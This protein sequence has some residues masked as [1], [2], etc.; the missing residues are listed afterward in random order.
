MTIKPKTKEQTIGGSMIRN[1][2][3]FTSWRLSHKVYVRLCSIH[4][5]KP[6]ILG[7]EEFC[8]AYNTLR[9][10]QYIYAMAYSISWAMQ[11][12]LAMQNKVGLTVYVRPCSMFSLGYTS[13]YRAMQY[14][15]G[16]REY[17]GLTVCVKLYNIC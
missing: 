1:T 9:V 7:H 16:N 11:Y 4:E 13:I 8:R 12:I 6:N 14:I 3:C 2:I 17:V 10:K 5:F 15:L